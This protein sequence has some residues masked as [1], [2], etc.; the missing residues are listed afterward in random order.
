LD[1]NKTFFRKISK[2]S[3]SKLQNGGLTKPLFFFFWLS[4][5]HFSTEFNIYFELVVTSTLAPRLA[6]FFFIQ[7]GVNFQDGD[8]TFSHQTV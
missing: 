5:S 3:F 6:Q 2:I 1:L 7:N 4:R 8:L